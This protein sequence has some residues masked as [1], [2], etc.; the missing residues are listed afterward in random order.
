MSKAMPIILVVS[1]LAFAGVIGFVMYNK[2]S[3]KSKDV[4]ERTLDENILSVKVDKDSFSSNRAEVYKSKWSREKQE[5]RK[6]EDQ[7][8]FEEEDEITVEQKEEALPVIEEKEVEKPRVVIKYVEKPIEKITEPAVIETKTRRT[9]SGFAT[10]TAESE[11]A[12]ALSSAMEFSI[13]AIIHEETE[14]KSGGSVL[15][16]TTQQGV[17]DGKEI[18]ANTLIPCIASISSNRLLL[19]STSFKAAGKIVNTIVS[20]Y[21]TDGAEGILVEGD[22]DQQIRKDVAGDVISEASKKLNVPIL[23]NLPERTSQRKL[24]DPSIIL[25]KGREIILRQKTK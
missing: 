20:V 10:S 11:S 23:R 7:D 12:P 4:T 15:I 24:Q 3:G 6:V 17:L 25:R 14:I 22:V 16:R 18:P 8:F 19:Q 2:Y 13:Q 21:A 5:A 9:K 1:I